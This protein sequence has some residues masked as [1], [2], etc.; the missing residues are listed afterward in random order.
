M[1]NWFIWLKF[2]IVLVFVIIIGLIL[3]NILFRYLRKLSEK[4]KTELDDIIIKNLQNPIL[5]WTIIIGIYLGLKTIPL[6]KELIGIIDKLLISL[7]I[8]SV[9]ITLSKIVSGIIKIYSS[10][11]VAV[12]PLTSVTQNISILI[13]AL[14]GL[15]ILLNT[16]G[17]AITPILTALGIGGLAVA[18][19]LQDTLSNFFSGIYIALSKNIRP[20]DYIKLETGQEG[21]VIDVGWR[22]TQIKEL[23]NNII[24]IPNIK[25]SQMI[26][27]NYHVPDKE[28]S[29]PI[30]VGVDYKSD[31]EKVEKVTLDVA[32]EVMKSIPGGVPEFEPVMRYHTFGE[33][34]I[35][36]TVVLRC[37]EF[38]NQYIIR[39]EFIKKLKKRYDKEGINIPFP[40]RTINI[41]KE[42]I[43]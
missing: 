6:S 12:L 14:F 38:V 2:A 40:I 7:I 1:N 15:L 26:V 9:T 11:F 30:E 24:I 25:L 16:L 13:I 17:I 3:R 36:F 28:L 19:A 29:I 21:F 27:K 5:L 42:E 37:N 39:H 41:K 4:T 43:D 8:I 35:N 34:S 20:G 10:K 31:L 23:P 32:K 18:L 22:S 33:S